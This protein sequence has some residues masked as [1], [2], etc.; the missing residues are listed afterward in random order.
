MTG[1]LPVHW[2]SVVATAKQYPLDY[3]LHFPNRQ[4]LSDVAVEGIVDLYKALGVR[5]MVIHR[6]QYELFAHALYHLD[7]SLVL[8]VENHRL[9]SYEF[10]E[11]AQL[12]DWLTLDVEHLWKFTLQ[13]TSVEKLESFLCDFLERHSH[14]VRHVHLPGY[15]P[16]LVP[17]YDEHRPMYCSRD[18]VFRVLDLLENVG[19]DGLVVSEVIEEFQNPLD[20]R[21][22]RLLFDRWREQHRTER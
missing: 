17:G 9:N 19:H 13:D 1:H 21:M 5:V 7:L 14:K 11:W 16:G 22:D 3:A 2:R 8:A 6:P 10:E 4:E 12:N 20:L 15:A 18:M